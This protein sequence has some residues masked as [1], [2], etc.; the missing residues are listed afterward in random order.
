MR[1]TSALVS[2]VASVAMLSAVL[3]G[4]S[5]SPEDASACTPLIAPGEASGLVTATGAVGSQPTVDLP[6]PLVSPSPERTVLE[7]GEGLVAYEGMTV[8]YDAVLLD[9]QSGDTME[10]TSFDDR[11]LLSRAGGAGALW[12]A[13]VCAQA[14][15]RIAVTTSVEDSGLAGPAATA[16]QMKMTLV[17]VL[18]VHRVYLGKADGVNQLPQ[19]GMP[20]VVTAPDGTVGLT[21]PSGLAIP[22]E[23]RSATIKLGSGDTLAEGDEIVVQQAVWNW[24]A[25]TSKVSQRSSSWSSSPVARTL[26]RGDAQAFPDAVVDALVGAPVGSQLLVVIPDEDTGDAVVYVIDVLG[27]RTPAAK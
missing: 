25:E 26:S 3:V 4:C 27:V 21:T 23:D 20:V 8:E 22:S 7:H 24:S 11:A 13:F 5:A 2:S 12:D 14:G 19:D 10:A 9:G 6:A 16:E 18:D 1:R 15:D 17:I